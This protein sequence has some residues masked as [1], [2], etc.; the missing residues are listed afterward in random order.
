[1]R[2]GPLHGVVLE[3]LQ[4]PPGEPWPVQVFIA[5]EGLSDVLLYR[6]KPGG[7]WEY[8]SLLAPSTRDC[9]RRSELPTDSAQISDL[10]RAS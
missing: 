2:N 9:P 3:R 4:P 6:P 1:M 10:L 8:V 7:A 5:D